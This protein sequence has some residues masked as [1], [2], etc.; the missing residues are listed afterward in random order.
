MK[1]PY[2]SLLEKLIKLLLEEFGDRLISVVVYGSV[3]RGDNRKDSDV[4]LLIVISRLPKTLTERIMLF[5]K[6]ENKI[7]D[8]IEKLMNE[9]YYISFSPIIKTPEEAIRFSPIYMDMTEDAIIL[10][11][12]DNFF[13]KVLEETR[14]R[15]LKLGFER[16]WISKK[17]WYWR[18]KD[19]KFGE[20]ID[21]G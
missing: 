9:G 11:D 19:Y 20:V 2:K 8:Y 15:L 14:E 17:T 1:E 21:F 10:Y 18:K 6:V 3:A 4:D 16:V 7:E 5:E 13:R 12:R